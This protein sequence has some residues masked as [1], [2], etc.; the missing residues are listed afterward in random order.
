M[1]E[2]EKEGETGE[3]KEG[4][5]EVGEEEWWLRGKRRGR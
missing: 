3:R 5:D 2:K 1:G 4:R